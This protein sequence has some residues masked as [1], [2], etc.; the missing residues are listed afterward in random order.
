MSHLE[1]TPP[2]PTHDEVIPFLSRFAS[3]TF[4]ESVGDTLPM[5]PWATLA[6]RVDIWHWVPSVP[7]GILVFRNGKIC[8]SQSLEKKAQHV[9]F[10]QH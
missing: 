4:A 3:N 6:I 5:N 10:T 8:A 1:A 2:Q 7:K 9:R